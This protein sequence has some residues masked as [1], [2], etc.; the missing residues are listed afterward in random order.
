MVHVPRVF[1]YDYCRSGNTSPLNTELS[2]DVMGGRRHW[3]VAS[4][5]NFPPIW[6][7]INNSTR[8][9]MFEK[10]LVRCRETKW[11]G[12]RCWLHTSGLVRKGMFCRGIYVKVVHGAPTDISMEYWVLI[13]IPYSGGY[14]ESISQGNESIAVVKVKVEVEVKVKVYVF[15][16]FHHPCLIP[17]TDVTMCAVESMIIG[18]PWWQT[19]CWLL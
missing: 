5:S 11:T 15:V 1:N 10:L 16:H 17:H 9:Y 7:K 19:M 2:A 13:S 14:R 8:K 3:G 4:G 12:T 18:S 6:Y